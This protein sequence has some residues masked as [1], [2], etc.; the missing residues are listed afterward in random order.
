MT[1]ERSPAYL[2]QESGYLATDRAIERCSPDAS[3]LLV[4]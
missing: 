4:H 3:W 2:H 1:F